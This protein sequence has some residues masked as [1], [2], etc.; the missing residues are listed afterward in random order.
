MLGAGEPSAK[1]AKYDKQKIYNEKRKEKP[2]K[3]QFS[4]NFQF[5]FGEEEEMQATSARFVRLCNI[6]NLHLGRTNA[7]FLQVL[8]DW[9]EGKSLEKSTKKKRCCCPGERYYVRVPALCVY[10]GAHMNMDGHV[11]R[12]ECCCE[13]GGHRLKWASSSIIGSKYT[14]N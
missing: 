10:G 9:Y 11:L 2:R 4:L 14:A 7:D 3:P 8:M 6:A 13:K 5:N 1:K 12:M